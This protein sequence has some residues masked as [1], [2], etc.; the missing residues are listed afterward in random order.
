MQLRSN[1]YPMCKKGQAAVEYLTYFAF[2]LLVA[3]TFSVFILSQSGNE[4]SKRSQERFKSTL[5]YVAQSIKDVDELAKHTEKLDVNVTLPYIV[6][7]NNVSISDM[8]GGI[9]F[10]NT[11]IGNSQVYYYISIGNFS[12]N[13]RQVDA[14]TIEIYK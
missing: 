6:K 12:V 8:P 1:C 9:V 3:S 13:V 10:G 11:T 14:D 7:G 5:F 2:F 4:L